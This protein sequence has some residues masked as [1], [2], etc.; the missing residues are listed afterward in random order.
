M[1][2]AINLNTERR[3]LVKNLGILGLGSAMVSASSAI[4]AANTKT[5]TGSAYA[6]A[7]PL[8]GKAAIVTGARANMGRAFCQ[9]LAAMGA[10]I[11]IH[12]HRE[13]TRGEAEQ[14]A[15]MVNQE[16][17]EA[18]LVSGDLGNVKTVNNM[19]D[20]SYREFGG[21]DILVNNA[22]AIIKKP[23]AEFSDVDFEKLNAVNNRGLFYCM[24]AGAKHLRD[25][26][27]IINTGT[28][29]LAGAA[30]GYAVYSGTKAPVEEYTRCLA[31][32]LGGKRI[33]VNT[34]APGPID[35]P[36]FHSQENERSTAYAANLATEKRLGDVSDIVPLLEFLSMPESQWINGQTLFINGGYLT[37]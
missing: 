29:L 25:G 8:K 34:I 37:R 2:D 12:F 3:N 28:S 22:G 21:V 36:F 19:F 27:R 20:A 9:A 1:K 23:V 33:T 18:V 5:N 13:K 10:D 11:V 32:E 16:G 26:G 31:K 17:Q 15:Q 35:T 7:K 4:G 6:A 24:R 14:T 30:P